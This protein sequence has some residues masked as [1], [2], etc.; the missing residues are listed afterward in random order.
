MTTMNQLL[1]EMK[2]GKS[3]FK[4]VYSINKTSINAKA[5]EYAINFSYR[6]KDFVL[7]KPHNDTHVYVLQN[8]FVIGKV[9][10]NKHEINIIYDIIKECDNVL[11]KPLESSVK[12]INPKI[13]IFQKIDLYTLLLRLKN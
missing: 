7:I 8:R 10:L 12:I 13:D 1:N 5:I 3:Y 6:S 4:S 11:D 2:I 9:D